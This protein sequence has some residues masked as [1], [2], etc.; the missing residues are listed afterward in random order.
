MFY[1]SKL[2]LSSL[3]Q[4]KHILFILDIN[5]AMRLTFLLK[6]IGKIIKNFIS[7]ACV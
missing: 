7:L 2:L 3:N 4:V 5:G 6:G 1:P